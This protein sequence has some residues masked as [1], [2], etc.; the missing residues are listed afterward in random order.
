MK[1]SKAKSP[2]TDYVQVCK[3]ELDALH[4]VF[5]S[6]EIDIKKCEE[7]LVKSKALEQRLGPMIE[8]YKRELLIN[9]PFQLTTNDIK[10]DKIFGSFEIKGVRGVLLFFRSFQNSLW[11]WLVTRQS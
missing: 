11:F 7:I 4:N 2:I 3:T 1:A 5:D 10:I 6:F 8:N 9:Q